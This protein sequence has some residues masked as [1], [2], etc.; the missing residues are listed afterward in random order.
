MKMELPIEIINEIISQ[1]G[2]SCETLNSWFQLSTYFQEYVKRETCIVL[3]QDGPEKVANCDIP[4]GFHPILDNLAHY[5]LVT[6]NIDGDE[7]S[8]FLEDYKNIIIIIHTTRN[9]SDPLNSALGFIVRIC[10]QGAKLSVIYN[11]SVNYLSRL[12]FREFIH[13]R[14]RVRLCELYIIGNSLIGEESMCDICMLFE[15]TYLQN[16]DTIFSLEIQDEDHEIFATSLATI[17][18]LNSI[19]SKKDLSQILINCPSLLSID[20]CNFPCRFAGESYKLAK[21]EN[22]TL[23]FFNNDVRYPVIDGTEV[24]NSLTLE[25]SLRSNNVEF[26]NLEFPNVKSLTLRLKDSMS[27]SVRL[28]DCNFKKVEILNIGSSIISWDDIINSFMDLN[29]LSINIINNEQYLW[30]QK[31]PF[32]LKFVNITSQEKEFAYYPLPV[33]NNQLRLSFETISFDLINP[34][35]CYLFNK[36]SLDNIKV[37]DTAIVNISNELVNRTL[38]KNDKVLKKYGLV[39]DQSQIVLTLSTIKCLKVFKKNSGDIRRIYA[40]HGHVNTLNT[41]T[42][43]NPNASQFRVLIA[44]DTLVAPY[45]MLI[46]QELSENTN[47]KSDLAS[48]LFFGN[49]CHGRTSS[50]VTPKEDVKTNIIIRGHTPENIVMNDETFCC[51]NIIWNLD[52]SR[53]VQALQVLVDPIPFLPGIDNTENKIKLLVELCQNILDKKNSTIF[54]DFNY[55]K[56]QIV[57]DFAFSGTAILPDFKNILVSTLERELLATNQNLAVLINCQNNFQLNSVLLLF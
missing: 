32:K 51:S 2:G 45:T 1:S 46:D 26:K 18:E 9:Y 24:T 57:I 35:R 13:S 54:A 6:D 19:S 50:S 33:Y 43:N 52:H 27:R 36:I 39:D 31:C 15:R 28:I 3:I 16:I 7:L 37:I 20:S 17:K 11:T 21:C 44:R 49:Q 41:K 12:Y 48:E 29:S 40:G 55:L 42:L 38:S 25:P 56:F 4:K 30:L 34:W 10:Y 23:E 14:K 22:I 47:I 8:L 5:Y 53:Q